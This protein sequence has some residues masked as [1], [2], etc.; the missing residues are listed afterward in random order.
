MVVKEFTVLK[1]NGQKI[2]AKAFIPAEDGKSYP[3][4]IFAH[5][6]NENYRNFQQHGPGYA[7]SGIACI[8]FDFCGGGTES[9]SDGKLNEMTICTEMEDL[10][11]MIDEVSAFDYVDANRLFL[12]GE[13]MGGFV[14]AYVA[15]KMPERIKALVLWYPAFVVPDD[16]KRRF[17]N[18]DNTCFG[19][20]LSPDFNKV[21]MDIDIFDVISKY[22]GPVKLIHG[23]EDSV[24]SLNYSERAVK[25]FKDASL[26]VMPGAGHGFGEEDS[27][28]A[29][30]LTIEF[31]M[32]Q[33]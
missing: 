12:H 14:S 32:K 8:F 26:T 19:L 31:I 22:T 1:K 10:E 16:S 29:R 7:E 2:A 9:L 4:V 18:N 27:T 24:V 25:S 33:L 30:E 23:D 11:T 17:E 3:T 20:E 21:S 6:F 13:S 5:G 15:A 28:K